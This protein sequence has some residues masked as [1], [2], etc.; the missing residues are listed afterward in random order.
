MSIPFETMIDNLQDMFS[1][2]DRDS[3]A[4]IL[5]ANHCHI[6]R[7]IEAC[8]SMS[9]DS[10]P[11]PSS[12]SSNGTTTNNNNT[13][14]LLDLGDDTTN[15]T[16]TTSN[17]QE[18]TIAPMNPS[19][20]GV[21]ATTVS[22]STSDATSS[23]TSNNSKGK[24]GSACQLPD[25]FLRP[26]GHRSAA[27]GTSDPNMLPDAELA[28]L[29]QN[30]LFQREL[31]EHY[32][33]QYSNYGGGM[34]PQG[35][36]PQEQVQ[37]Q[38]SSQGQSQMMTPNRGGHGQTTGYGGGPSTS[39]SASTSGQEGGG[40]SMMQRIGDMGSSMKAQLSALGRSFTAKD[41]SGRRSRGNRED[42]DDETETISFMQDHERQ[43]RDIEMNPILANAGESSS[44]SSSSSFSS[45]NIDGNT[46]TNTNTNSSS[47]WDSSHIH[48]D[49]L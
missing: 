36:Q 16:N 48:S 7:T 12:T 20:R 40:K 25:A 10:G 15:I 29:L 42:Y 11:T 37:G 9:A 39:T 1:D 23:S 45:V 3:L 19:Y 4:A 6:E 49:T 14:N 38:G 17:H 2:W 8:L 13:E 34:P 27:R 41:R 32:G 35:G 24:R 43:G 44:S 46:N 28:R 30:E 33:D 22:S 26:P 18:N 5:E 47:N 31:R 21:A